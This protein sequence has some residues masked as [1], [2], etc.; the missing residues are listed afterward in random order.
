[1]REGSFRETRNDISHTCS[2]RL[3]VLEVNDSGD[4]N[5]RGP[6]SMEQSRNGSWEIYCLYCLLCFCMCSKVWKYI[7]IGLQH[8]WLGLSSH[9]IQVGL[10]CQ[11]ENI[12]AIQKTYQNGLAMIETQMDFKCS[13]FHTCTLSPHSSL[14]CVLSEFWG[15]PKSLNQCM[16]PL[17]KHF[18]L[19]WEPWNVHKS[20]ESRIMNPLIHPFFQVQHY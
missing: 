14:Q 8:K 16:L 19:L 4:S 10:G 5:F 13:H 3:E 1:M 11:R 17:F 6:P 18:C 12:Q 15:S 7:S 20:R 9:Q 2:L